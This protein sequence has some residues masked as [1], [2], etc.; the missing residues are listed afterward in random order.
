MQQQE[1]TLNIADRYVS[2]WGTWEVAR[3]VISNARDEGEYDVDTPDANT[4]IVTTHTSPSLTLLTVVGAGTK[5]SDGQTIGQF[6]EGFKLA[7]LT[8]LRMGGSF[9][10]ETD[11]YFADFFL[12]NIDGF[13]ILHVRVNEWKSS[14]KKCTIT[15]RLNNI[16]LVHQGKFLKHPNEKCINTFPIPK[17][18]PSALTV[19]IRGVYV[20]QYNNKTSLNDWN[21]GK[22]LLN[23]DR[24]IIDMYSLY[25]HIT[26][27]YNMHIDQDIAKSLIENPGCW[28]IECIRY[29]SFTPRSNIQQSLWQCLQTMYGN[30]IVI[31]STNKNANARA[32]SK[33]KKPIDI[34]DDLAMILGEV[35]DNADRY[36]TG[37]EGYV[38]V[39]TPDCPEFREC[40]QILDY[41][42]IDANL[43]IFESDKDTQLGF[44]KKSHNLIGLNKILLGRSQREK[45]ISVL[46]H[47][48]GHIISGANDL[49]FEFQNCLTD[50]CAKIIMNNREILK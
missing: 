12:K 42:D 20:N 7:A 23:R 2:N 25:S 3:E 36:L 34:S 49:T 18:D 16:G 31:S 24:S 26:T 14:T 40:L 5:N 1:L 11:K 28:E 6:G 21:I 38:T 19:F 29:S 17:D 13:N 8:T 39:P 15:I 10:I 46:I 32:A 48:V 35:A 33:G 37:D 43:V 9:T 4:L 27:Y 44:A 30:N 41:L 22:A 50:I 47:E 45:R